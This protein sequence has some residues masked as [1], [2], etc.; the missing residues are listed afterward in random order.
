MGVEVDVGVKGS[1]RDAGRQ[2]PPATPQLPASI[3]VEAP[4]M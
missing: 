3:L 1:R 2:A 4:G